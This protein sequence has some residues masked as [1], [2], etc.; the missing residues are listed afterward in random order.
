MEAMVAV[1]ASHLP[2]A[3]DHLFLLAMVMV[4]VMVLVV[5]VRWRNH[6]RSILPKTATGWVGRRTAPKASERGGA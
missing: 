4:A 1:V 6:R 5:L 3:F 2:A